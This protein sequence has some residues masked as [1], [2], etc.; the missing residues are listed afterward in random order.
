M[1]T[2]WQEL[3]QILNSYKEG[4]LRGCI[5]VTGNYYIIIAHTRSTETNLMG[6]W[7]GTNT[8]LSKYHSQGWNQTVNY[9]YAQKGFPWMFYLYL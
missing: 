3:C 9:N 4:I 1:P 7:H 6:L 8:N 5:S 2:I